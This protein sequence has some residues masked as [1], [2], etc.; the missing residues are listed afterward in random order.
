MKFQTKQIKQVLAGYGIELPHQAKISNLKMTHPEPTTILYSFRL[1]KQ[2]WAILFDQDAEDDKQIIT[3]QL[4]WTPEQIEFFVNPNLETSISLPFNQKTCYLVRQ[5][6]LLERLD[7]LLTKKRPNLSRSKIAKLVKNKQ[8]TVDGEIITS[9]S[10]KL[11]S[12]AKIELKIEENQSKELPK[13]EIIYQDDDIIAVNKPAGLLTHPISEHDHSESTL[14]D[15]IRAK[16]SFSQPNYRSGI[17]HRL[18][19]ATSGIILLAKNDKAE[20]ELKNQFKNR[21]IQKTYLAITTGLAKHLQAK[22]D[23][24]LKRSIKQPGKFQVDANGKPAISFYQVIEQNP[25]YNLIEIKPQ[26][27]RTHQIRVHLSYLNLPI[28]GDYLYGGEKADRLYLH[29]Q[30]IEFVNLAGQ[31]VSLKTKLPPE[32]EQW[33]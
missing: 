14:A 25:P 18:D 12:T 9:P 22:I 23:L 27:G 20:R 26:T 6:D 7:V 5:K 19:R 30:A 28:V 8:A 24:P 17:V 13:L 21:Q 4:D 16:G 3:D 2:N 32:F 33:I 29:A 31:K 10:K 15:F 11:P 1:N